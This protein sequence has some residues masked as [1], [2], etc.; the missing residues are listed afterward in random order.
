LKDK[1]KLLPA[2]ERA[3]EGFLQIGWSDG[4]HLL[5][6]IKMRSPQLTKFNKTEK[7]EKVRKNITY[8]K[9]VQIKVL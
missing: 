5:E 4:F 9:P 7:F 2:S 1:R 3:G 8:L 6:P